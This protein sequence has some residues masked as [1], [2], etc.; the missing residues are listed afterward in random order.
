MSRVRVKV[1][2]RSDS[3]LTV[4]TRA[5]KFIRQIGHRDQGKGDAGAVNLEQPGNVP[6]AH[7]EVGGSDG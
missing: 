5:G 6:N 7:V 3:M 1:T 4:F 2:N